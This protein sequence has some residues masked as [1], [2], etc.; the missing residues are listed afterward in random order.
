MTGSARGR[1]ELALGHGE[2]LKVGTDLRLPLAAQQATGD[3]LELGQP[4]RESCLPDDDQAALGHLGGLGDRS[5]GQ[6]RGG[7]VL[8]QDR[9]PLPLGRAQ[10]GE[11]VS[12]GLLGFVKL[13]DLEIG[14][15]AEG[16]EPVPVQETG[17]GAVLVRIG[18]AERLF[19]LAPGSQRL[20]LVAEEGAFLRVP[21][22]HPRGRRR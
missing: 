7:D 20:G 19:G 4:H 1:G 2:L 14:G 18:D 21:R 8:A 13:A 12:G 9:G 17:P 22:R 15:D 11:Q 3:V 16:V 10:A 5:A 6:V